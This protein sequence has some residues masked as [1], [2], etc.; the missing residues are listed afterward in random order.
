MDKMTFRQVRLMKEISQQQLADAI[1][2]HVNTVM[3]WEKKPDNIPVSKAIAIANFLGCDI[4][5]IIF[6]SNPT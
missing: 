5:S 6:V 1:G 3:H 4:T 2:V